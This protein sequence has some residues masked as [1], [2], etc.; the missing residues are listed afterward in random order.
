[1]ARRGAGS[2]PTLVNPPSISGT[3]IL[4]GVL[5]VDDGL[6]VGLLPRTITRQWYRG[7]AT[8][9]GGATGPTY[10]VQAADQLTTVKCLVTCTNIL[11]SLTVSTPSTTTIP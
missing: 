7:A 3:P 6:F 1:M 10:T 5:T 11:G 9:I 8:L 4:A 2:V